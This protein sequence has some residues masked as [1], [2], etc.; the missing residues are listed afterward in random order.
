M[1]ATRA[2]KY[3]RVICP[4]CG[5]DNPRHIIEEID[6]NRPLYHYSYG[7]KPMYVKIFRCND[8]KHGWEKIN[9]QKKAT[10]IKVNRRK[11]SFTQFFAKW[12]K[13][14]KIKKRSEKINV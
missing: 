12:N 10:A 6:L 4:K 7:Q 9:Q 1:T 2:S 11:I 5:N 3:S 14:N 8:C 13:K